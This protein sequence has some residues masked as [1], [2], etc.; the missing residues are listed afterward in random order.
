M[1]AG[2]EEHPEGGILK[3]FP[4]R[5]PAYQ[6]THTAESGVD[7]AGAAAGVVQLQTEEGSDAFRS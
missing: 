2:K 6:Y 5:H 3:T 1:Q 7:S 4:G